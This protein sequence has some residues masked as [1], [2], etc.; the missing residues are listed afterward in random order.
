MYVKILE[1]QLPLQ[2]VPAE[3]WEPQIVQLGPETCQRRTTQ[4]REVVPLS[5]CGCGGHG[6]GRCQGLG[7]NVERQGPSRYVYRWGTGEPSLPAELMIR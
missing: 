5:G 4:K 2:Y 6:C 3:E 1:S 7:R